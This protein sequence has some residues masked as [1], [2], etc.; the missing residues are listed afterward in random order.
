MRVTV[1]K[2][3]VR[4]SKQMPDTSF[5][6][7]ELGLEGSLT[8]SDA[9]WAEVQRDLY[10]ALGEQMRYVFSSNGSGKVQHGPEKP[11]ETT[12]SQPE[13]QELDHFCRKHQTPFRKYTKDTRSWWSH[14]VGS[15]W[16]RES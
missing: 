15:A 1:V 16:C 4:Y 10:H 7:V 3:N 9:D 11:V 14:R 13:P 6:T 12:P 8:N 5:K 2:V